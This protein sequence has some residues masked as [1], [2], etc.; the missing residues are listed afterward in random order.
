LSSPPPFLAVPLGIW[1]AT[2]KR[3]TKVY[4]QSTLHLAGAKACS[5]NSTSLPVTFFLQQRMHVATCFPP[6]PKFPPF[7]PPFPPALVPPFVQCRASI[8]FLRI[9]IQVP[10]DCVDNRGTV[11]E[12]LPWG[13][14]NRLE[15]V[16]CISTV[17]RENGNSGC[18]KRKMNAFH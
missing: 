16:A 6:P 8:R 7:H 11:I 3:K 5:Y 10:R 14:N 4:P 2:K 15:F 18:G 17:E 13:C 9:Y 12:R 1:K